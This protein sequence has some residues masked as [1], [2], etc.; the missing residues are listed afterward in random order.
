MPAGLPS[1]LVERRPDIMSAEAQLRA[2]NADIGAA[3]TA[4]F[5][6]FSLTSALGSLS[7]TFPV[8]SAGRPSF[9]R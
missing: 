4:Y 9:G 2:A 7:G 1:A 6:T 8:C 3:R 5:P